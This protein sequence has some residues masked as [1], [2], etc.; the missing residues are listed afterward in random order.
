MKMRLTQSLFFSR[1]VI[2][3]M[4]TLLSAAP[5][6]AQT[7]TTDERVDISKAIIYNP[8]RFLYYDG[9]N[10][11]EELTI[12]VEVYCYNNGWKKLTQDT[13]YT[14]HFIDDDDNELD[15]VREKGYY[16]LVVRGIGNYKGEALQNVCVTEKGNW[17]DHRASSFSQVDNN[18]SVVTI[19][20]E[21][22]LALLAY[23]FN[24]K[25]YMHAEYSG[26]TF[27]LARDM[28]LSDYEWTPIG[29]NKPGEET[30][31][32]GHFDGQG[33]TIKGVHFERK[34]SDSE[35]NSFFPQG[36]FAYVDNG[37]SIKNLRLTD[38]EI[39]SGH[40]KG[41]GGIAGYLNLN[42]TITN[43]HVTQSVNV[44]CLYGNNDEYGGDSYGG[45]AG[46]SS[47]AMSGC[48]SAAHVFKVMKTSGCGAFGGIVGRC[49][50]SSS[51]QITD[52]IYYG[53]QVFADSDAGAVV[54]YLANSDNKT[55]SAY[56]TSSNLKG[57]NGYGP[58][59]LTQ[60]EAFDQNSI[61]SVNYG[62]DLTKQYDYDGIKVYPKAMVYGGACYTLPQNIT[63]LEG[64]GTRSEPYLIKTTDD[65]DMLASGINHGASFTDKY[66][67]LCNDL[68]YD[69]RAG[70]YTAIG[71][72]DGSAGSYFDGIFEGYNHS[73]SGINIHKSGS[74]ATD[75][76]QGIFGWT[77]E[78]AVV[79]NLVVRNST[80]DAFNSTGAIVGSNSG[81]IE[82]CHVLDGVSVNAVTGN[83]YYHGGIAGYNS[84]TGIVIDCS[85][86]VTMSEIGEGACGS[87]GGIVGYNDGEMRDCL[88]LGCEIHGTTY[89]GALVGYNGDGSLKYNYYSACDWRNA[90]GTIVKTSGIGCG[91]KGSISNDIETTD[92]AVPALRDDRDNSETI[93][94]LTDRVKYL[95]ENGFEAATNIS[96]NGRT[97]WKDGMWNTLCLPFAVSSFQN[98][99]LEGAMV[100]M[101]NDASFT[102][103]T[104]TLQ[105]V[106]V[107]AIDA[108][109]PY[110]VKWP[111]DTENPSIT[112]PVFHH[113]KP[114][115]QLDPQTIDD[116]ICFKGNFSPYNVYG[117]DKKLLYLGNDSK[118]Y[119][120]EDAMTINAFRA[121]FL[122][123][124]DLICGDLAQGI[125]HFVLNYGGEA[126]GIEEISNLKDQ[127][128]DSDAWYSIGGQRLNGKPT[129]KGIYINHG[130]K[131]VIN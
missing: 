105:F 121:Y 31:F 116:V 63:T 28:D 56:Y 126:S 35:H 124:G 41:V 16:N 76:Y 37:S 66:F 103:N 40:N 60:V 8:F 115:Q 127:T 125:N 23:N 64:S 91:G 22:E 45:V 131:V 42:T 106:G 34:S 43:C 25:Y 69:G 14:I 13:D 62:G 90:Q 83:T 50:F 65:L 55:V 27:R 52:C 48:T 119:Y 26:W 94:Q 122:L 117:E 130:H 108:G 72:W 78:N 114:D 123:Q 100:M 82:N 67:L 49:Y 102:D 87:L 9:N 75:G 3:L 118:L 85:S 70:N 20:S 2:M 33:H 12:L 11:Y 19:T 53:D 10:L 120:P 5:A 39:V 93:T 4:L 77:G 110:I 68:A 38:S 88:A 111:N 86:T 99:P 81:R 24:S 57:L 6:W 84:S 59:N 74:A 47:A 15:D 17:V 30:G 113:V 129:T 32:R 92:A 101:L 51:G 104:L 98:S 7:D 96:I 18:N 29:S 44:V 95:S 1:A 58:Y 71:Y 73:I 80:F 79:K 97:L 46:Y 21:E 61:L 36:L 128:P 89:Q 109:K 107:T 54:G 112:D